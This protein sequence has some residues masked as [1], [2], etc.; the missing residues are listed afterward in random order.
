MTSCG[1]SNGGCGNF[2]SFGPVGCGFGFIS[3]IT[4]YLV[5]VKIN[6]EEK[7][8]KFRILR[9]T[10]DSTDA[11]LSSHLFDDPVKYS[12]KDVRD[13]Q[14]GKMLGNPGKVVAGIKITKD[15]EI[16]LTSKH[17]EQIKNAG[18]DGL[19]AW[20]KYKKLKRSF[21]ENVEKKEEEEYLER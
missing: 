18:E 2:A 12:F 7:T 16:K 13:I 10:V 21:M 8:V 17:K 4:D 6:E 11:V 15:G 5:P 19:L 20:K 1:S 3:K 14:K 9:V